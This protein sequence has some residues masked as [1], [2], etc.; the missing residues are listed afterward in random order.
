MAFDAFTDQAAQTFIDSQGPIHYGKTNNRSVI[1]N[2]TNR[3]HDSYRFLDELDKTQVFQKIISRRIN[4][5]LGLGYQKPRELLDAHLSPSMKVTSSYRGYELDV[6]LDLDQEQVIR[7]VLVPNYFTLDDLHVVIQKLF[8]WMDYHLH[9]FMNLSNHHI[10]APLED[11]FIV[12]DDTLNSRSMSVEDA[13]KDFDEWLY[14]YDFGDDWQHTIICNHTINQPEPIIPFCSFYDG[15][16]VPE[17]VGG[18]HGY[19]HFKQVMSQETHEAYDEYQS[20]LASLDYEPFDLD[21]VNLSLLQAFSY[22]FFAELLRMKLMEN[23]EE[24]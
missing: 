24:E 19:H 10:Y 5:A 17:D 6:I 18:I 7:R 22:G 15:E 3:K 1:S 11:V 20:W 16:N 12:H 14:T 23:E 13:F 2:T 8:G 21:Q 4:H 9:Q